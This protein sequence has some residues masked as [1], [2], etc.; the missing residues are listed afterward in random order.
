M[1]AFVDMPG[2]YGAHELSADPPEDTV[3]WDAGDREHLA[4]DAAP[5]ERVPART[6]DARALI[7]TAPGGRG[8]GHAGRCGCSATLICETASGTRT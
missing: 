1:P 2:D 5:E 4:D 7:D 3:A 8:S 6:G